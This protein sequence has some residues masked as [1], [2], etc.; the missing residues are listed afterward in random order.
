MTTL[1]CCQA[2]LYE[3]RLRMVKMPMLS[4]PNVGNLMT[5]VRTDL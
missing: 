4:M 3:L 5:I 2:D 1:H